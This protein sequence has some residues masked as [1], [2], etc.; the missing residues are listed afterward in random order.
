M[1]EKVVAIDKNGIK[2]ARI[3][4]NPGFLRIVF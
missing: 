2:R 4:G 1:A 3:G